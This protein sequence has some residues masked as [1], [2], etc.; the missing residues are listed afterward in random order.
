MDEVAVEKRQFYR[1]ALRTES[2][3][4]AKLNIGQ[5]AASKHDGAAQK[6]LESRGEK[7][8]ERGSNLVLTLQRPE[9]FEPPLHLMFVYFSC[10][11][12][13]FVKFERNILNSVE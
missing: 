11:G 2:G 4:R 12:G 5:G 13:K 10:W 7:M 6:A 9:G 1:F 8:W 3:R